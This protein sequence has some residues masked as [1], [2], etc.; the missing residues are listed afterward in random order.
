MGHHLFIWRMPHDTEGGSIIVKDNVFGSV[1]YG[2]AVYSIVS[3]EA[4]AQF[5]FEG[6]TYEKKDGLIV[7]WGGENYLAALPGSIPAGCTWNFTFD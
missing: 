3:P 6:N 2:A 1:P 4:E 5:I 7:R